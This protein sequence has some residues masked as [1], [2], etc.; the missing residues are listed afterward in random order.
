MGYGGRVDE[1]ILDSRSI[2]SSRSV[3]HS[4]YVGPTGTF[5]CDSTTA[6]CFPLTPTDVM[7][8]AVMA[9]NA[10]SVVEIFQLSVAHQLAI[11]STGK[12]ADL[13]TW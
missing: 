9:L 6:Q 3:H 2:S 11:E 8:A 13:P 7:L 10:Y 12:K 4:W 5:F 1:F